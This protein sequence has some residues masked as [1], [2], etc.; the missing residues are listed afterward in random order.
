MKLEKWLWIGRDMRMIKEL[1]PTVRFDGW[2][3]FCV[4]MGW[5]LS[6]VCQKVRGV[7][8][9]MSSE[10]KKRKC[11]NT[12]YDRGGMKLDGRS[13][14]YMMYQKRERLRNK[15]ELQNMEIEE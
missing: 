15:K 11:K 1:L 5:Y 4:K 3:F 6:H 2:Y 7:R 10:S 13:K 12:L 9:K 14:R 8:V